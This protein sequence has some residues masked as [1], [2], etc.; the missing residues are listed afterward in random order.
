MINIVIVE[1]QTMLLDGIA[2]ALSSNEEFNIVGKLTDISLVSDFIKYKN[3]D[4]LLTDVYTENK[5]NSLNFIAAIKKEKPQIKIVVMT[6]LPE[7]TYAETAKNNGADSFIYKNISLNEMIS[8]IKNTL[9]GYNI[10]PKPK[11]AVTRNPISTLTKQEM[12]VLRLFCEGHDR[13]EIGD[14]L[15][16][17]E[18]SVKFHIK[19]ILSKTNYSSMTRLAIN[20]IT[21]KLIIID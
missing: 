19:N 6:G 4:V 3:V 16:I 5:N 21:N 20:A 9:N 10:Y 14:I 17:S 8:V 13:R 18:N 12:R 15:S 7:I 2:N 1:D 11:D